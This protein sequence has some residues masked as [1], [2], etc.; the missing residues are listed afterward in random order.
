MKQTGRNFGLDLLR[1]LAIAIVLGNHYFIGFHISP[2]RVAWG[3]WAAGISATAILSIEWLFVLS[4]FLIG[5][6][7]IRSFEAGQTW[8]ARARD[9]WL[10]RWFRTLPNYYLFLAFNAALA[11]YG[12]GSGAFDYKFALFSQ[13]LAW[14]EKSP[15]FF[16]EAWSLAS[17]EWFYFL[18]PILLGLAAWVFRAGARNTFLAVAFALI[19]APTLARLFAPVPTDFFA[20]DAAIRRVTVF[21]LDA[22]GWGVLAAIVSRWYADQWARHQGARAVLGVVLTVAG[23]AM[24]ELLVLVGWSDTLPSRMMNVFSL[25]LPA[26]RAFVLLPWLTELRSTS[27][28]THWVVDRVSLYSYSLYLCH[29]PM[30]FI[31]Q[32]WFGINKT[33]SLAAVLA[34]TAVWLGL[35]FGLAA[36]VFRFFEKPTSD[37]RER[38]TKRVDASPFLG[39]VSGGGG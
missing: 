27:A 26:A 25:V 11:A 29:F 14:A 1:T 23:M 4:G 38:F 28:A 19:L 9:F 16:G 18:M 36:V 13:N 10:R 5:T 17:D 3:G 22:T 33:S 35:T 39:R 8:W 6:M 7:M 24:V 12:I 31:V 21:H 37:M 2:G 20:W 15:L 34:A 32:A 30:I